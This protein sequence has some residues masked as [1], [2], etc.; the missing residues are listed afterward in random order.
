MLTRNESKRQSAFQATYYN[1]G[2]LKDLACKVSAGMTGAKVAPGKPAVG[3]SSSSPSSSA[4][5]RDSCC[6]G[7]V[8][9]LCANRNFRLLCPSSCGCNYGSFSSSSSGIVSDYAVLLQCRTGAASKSQSTAPTPP[10]CLPSPRRPPAPTS[11]PTAL[12]RLGFPS[13]AIRVGGM[14]MLGLQRGRKAARALAVRRW[15]R[16]AESPARSAVGEKGAPRHALGR[17]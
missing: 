15:R 1:E 7:A 10:S 6:R 13:A 14:G 8:S 17:E 16:S 3:A 11:I 2:R 9:G 4:S 5:I 12:V